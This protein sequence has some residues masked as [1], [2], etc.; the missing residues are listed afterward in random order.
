MTRHSLRE[1]VS[2]GQ[3]SDIDRE[4][5]KLATEL[6]R[7]HEAEINEVSR[8]T[9]SATK[10]IKLWRAFFAKD[11]DLR[12]VSPTLAWQAFAFHPGS[13]ASSFRLRDDEQE[14]WS[15][16][17]EQFEAWYMLATTNSVP[18]ISARDA[19]LG[20]AYLA[21]TRWLL[22]S[23]PFRADVAH[24]D[25][26]DRGYVDFGVERARE[27]R[28]QWLAVLAEIDKHSTLRSKIDVEAESDLLARLEIGEKTSAEADQSG[29]QAT[30]P[31]K[32]PYLRSIAGYIIT[33]LL[34]PRFAWWRSWTLVRGNLGR[35]VSVHGLATAAVFAG[36]LVAFVLTAL[37]VLGTSSGYTAAAVIALMGYVSIAVGA[38]FHRELGWLWLLR[39]PASSAVGLL[40]LAALPADW[41]AVSDRDTLPTLSKSPDR[42]AASDG[43]AILLASVILIGVGLAYLVIEASNHGASGRSLFGRALGV[44]TFGLLH[45][46]MVSLIGLRFL[47]P[48]FASTA[49]GM[50]ISC[51]WTTT[52]CGNA[53]LWPAPM[54]L[55][56]TAW[57]FVSGVFLQ[58][59]WDDQPITAPLS[60][61][62]WKVGQ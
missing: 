33:H 13:V 36:A 12:A 25:P 50:P 4:V 6:R 14:P 59:L 22:L 44:G 45:A 61:V 10:R 11:L 60:H 57:S 17:V 41:W 27:A 53:A 39:Q 62:T 48:A 30:T 34:L 31:S 32:D 1:L 49:G 47:L 16:L 9:G 52:G 54:L 2:I 38:A 15:V 7:E 40:T 19:A 58:I 46:A 42:W 5:E 29:E 43:W 21:R 3:D 35:P 37:G 55:A 28:E 18:H 8:T 51:W 56:A 20:A 26:E 24:I 23:A